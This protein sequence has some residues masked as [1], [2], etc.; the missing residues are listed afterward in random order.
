MKYDLLKI[1]DLIFCIFLKK[2]QNKKYKAKR[3]I[4]RL[5]K[6]TWFLSKNLVILDKK[7][8]KFKT[9]QEITKKRLE[10]VK[11]IKTERKSNK[12]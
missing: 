10:T 12:I 8:L 6:I 1:H 5:I 3:E 4:S 2:K 11:I 7:L 9:L